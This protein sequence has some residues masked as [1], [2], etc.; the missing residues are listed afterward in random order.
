MTHARLRDLV[1]GLK[2]KAAETPKP[3]PVWTQLRLNRNLMNY[4]LARSARTRPEWR[5]DGEV[6]FCTLPGEDRIELNL[7]AVAPARCRRCPTGFDMNVLFRLLSA[8]QESKCDRVEVASLASFLR[9]MHL[10][11]DR[12]NVERLVDAFEILHHVS[13][14]FGCWYERGGARLAQHFPPPVRSVDLKGRCGLTVHLNR[15][16]ARLACEK[17]YF[18][19]VRLPLPQ[20]ASAQNYALMALTSVPTR[21][22]KDREHLNFSEPMRRATFCRKIGLRHEVKKVEATSKLV[23]RWFADGG[24]KIWVLQGG[25]ESNRIKA[26]HI[27]FAFTPPAVPRRRAGVEG[28]LAHAEAGVEGANS[29]SKRGSKGPYIRKSSYESE[30]INEPAK[31]QAAEGFAGWQSGQ[32]DSKRSGASHRQE[33]G[34]IQSSKVA[35]AT[36]SMTRKGGR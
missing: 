10:S 6:L 30:A 29:A 18:A 15:E 5:E 2:P 24:G 31:P 34:S 7:P 36:T 28:A 11:D 32:Y 35:A 13:I 1:D 27:A 19:R 21:V 8:A 9:D 22:G 14:H 20:E 23:E 25:G 12:A 16:W 4:P 17:H 33:F 3:E 26:G